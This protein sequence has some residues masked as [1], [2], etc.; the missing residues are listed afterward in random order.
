MFQ[1]FT[2]Y[3]DGYLKMGVPYFDCIIMK[4]G[5]CIYRHSNGYKDM[6]SERVKGNELYNVY[7]CSKPITCVAAMQLWEQGAFSLEDKLSDYMPEFTE[8]TVKT[9]NGI[10]PAEKPILIKHLFEMTAGF[11]YN[12]NSPSIKKLKSD[13][14]GE[15]P[16]REAM[17]YIAAEPLDFEPG[18]KWQ[19]S[20]C[21]DVLAAFIEVITGMRFGEYVKKNIFDRLGMNDTTF[22]LP[23]ERLSEIAPQY[24][25]SDF[26]RSAMHINNEIQLYKLGSK[27]E[28]G[29]AG[30]ITSLNDYVKFTEALRSGETLIKRSTV[31]LMTTPR[32]NE[33]QMESYWCKETNN[34]GLGI[35]CP[36]PGDF[37]R[38]FGWGGAA[39]AFLAID[40]DN[41]FS[42]FYVQH[43]LKAPN[44]DLRHQIYEHALEVLKK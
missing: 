21:H 17:K 12:I 5:E 20:L 33:K 30:C 6:K 23:E 36:K 19:Y 31:E 41:D 39:G 28:S 3:L 8:M 35:R 42:L 43:I 7:S 22:S 24:L 1:K 11:N 32:L 37:Y 25:Y 27:Y 14:N 34:Y 13:T 44:N 2:E 26:T 16:T 15:C 29:G 4:N 10:K 38:D 18:E 9:E 40:T